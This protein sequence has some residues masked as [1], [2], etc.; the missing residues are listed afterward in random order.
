MQSQGENR[1]IDGMFDASDRLEEG[2]VIVW[3][4]DLENDKRSIPNDILIIDAVVTAP[5]T[6][7]LNGHIRYSWYVCSRGGYEV[8]H[9]DSCSCFAQSIQASSTIS[10]ET[11]TTLFYF[12]TFRSALAWRGLLAQYLISSKEDFRSVLASYPSSRLKKA[13]TFPQLDRLW[14][15]HIRN[16]A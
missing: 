5:L 1:V 11:C 9:C 6:D 2:G 14:D 8:S 4:N 13:R 3:W 16:Q 10:G 15:V 12:W 7:M